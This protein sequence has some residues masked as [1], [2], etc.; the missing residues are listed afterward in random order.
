MAL[1]GWINLLDGQ[2][3][4]ELVCF[5]LGPVFRVPVSFLQFADELVL[6]T[7]DLLDLVVGKGPPLLSDLPR[8]LLPLALDGVPV[9]GALL[10]TECMKEQVGCRSF[11]WSLLRPWRTESG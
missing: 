6:F 3:P 5:F 10:E 4:G 8:Q 9:H 1:K 2:R 11:E 7:G